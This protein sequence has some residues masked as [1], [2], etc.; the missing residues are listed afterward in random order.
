MNAADAEARLRYVQDVRRRT[1]QAGTTPV[2]LVAILGALIIVRGI[3][4]LY[5]P[6]VAGISAAWFLGVCVIGLAAAVWLGHRQRTQGGVLPAPAGRWIAVL[7]IAAEVIAHAIGANVIIAG[8]AVPLSFAAWRVGM[9]PIA[10]AI[11]AI[12]I[13]SEALVLQGTQQWAALVI[14]GAGLV[15]V[16][17]AARQTSRQGP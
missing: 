15:A 11:S 5:W 12:G 3:L 8:M 14:F 17:I 2:L 1:R 9:Q 6:R 4:L 13:I 16:A 7:T 10:G